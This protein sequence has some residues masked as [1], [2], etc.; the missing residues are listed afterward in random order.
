MLVGISVPE[1][2]QAV[3]EEGKKKVRYVGKQ[4]KNKKKEDAGDESSPTQSVGGESQASST[5]SAPPT[6]RHKAAVCST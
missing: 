1:K 6:V 3:G 5:P 2:A 4:R